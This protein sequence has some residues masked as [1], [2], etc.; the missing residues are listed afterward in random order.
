MKTGPVNVC[1]K[2][3]NKLYFLKMYYSGSCRTV[4]ELFIVWTV[5]YEKLV[6]RVITPNDPTLKYVLLVLLRKTNRYDIWEVGILGSG[7]FRK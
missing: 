3:R 2:N 6:P 1:I 7:V 4:R 5:K